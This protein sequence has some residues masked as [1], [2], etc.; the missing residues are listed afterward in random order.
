MMID[1]LFW[2][3]AVS[4]IG[5]LALPLG[6]FLLPTLKDHGYAFSRV[7]GLMM[8]GFLYWLLVSYKML[9]NDPGGILMALI[10]FAGVSIG[11]GKRNP[12]SILKDIFQKQKGYVIVVEALFILLFAAMALLRST[13]PDI[14][15]TEKPMEL[16]FINAILRSGSFPPNDPWLAGY[17][18]SY[19]Y[20]GYVI[21]AM[22]IKLTA[23]PSG[24]GF[25]LMISLVFSL[26]GIGMYGLV[27]NIIHSQRVQ[28]WIQKYSGHEQ[29]KKSSSA[30]I[31]LPLLGPIFTLVVSNFEG[32]FEFLHARGLFWA[33]GADGSQQSSFWKWLDIQE[34]VM[35]PAQPFSWWPNRPGGIIWWR[36]SRVLSDY[37][38]SGNWLEIIDEFPFFSFLL[39]DL[40]PHV[41]ALP[42][43]TLMLALVLNVLCTKKEYECNL[44]GMVI[45]I[46]PVN[47]V[48]YTILLG[49][50]AF[51]NTWD[52]PVYLALFLSAYFIY[53]VGADGFK[54]EAI[55]KTISLGILM[56]AGSVIA[57]IPFYIGF[58]SQAGGIIP[59]VIFST[60]GVH[61]WIMFGILLIPIFCFLIVLFNRHKQGNAWIKGLWVSVA[62]LAVIWGG[63]FLLG[64]L[65]ATA[66]RW[67][68]LIPGALGYSLSEAG[69]YFLSI[70]G[71]LDISTGELFSAALVRR[72]NAPGT[73]LTLLALGFLISSIVL[74]SRK[75]NLQENESP[76]S[77]FLLPEGILYILLVIAAAIFLTIIPEFVYLRDQFGWRMN[78]IFK[79]YYQAWILWS[80]AA[81]TGLSL[82]WMTTKHLSGVLFKTIPLIIVVIGFAYPVIGIAYTTNNFQPTNKL[83]LDGTSYMARYNPDEAQAIEWLSK[84]PYGYVLEAVGGSYSSYARV[85]TLSGLPGVLGWP[86]HES[87]W[88][89]GAKEMGNREFDIERFYTT[90]DWQEAR[91][92]LAAYNVKYIY[93]GGLER[94][95]YRLDEDKISQNLTSV[96]Q[97]D[98]VTIYSF[99]GSK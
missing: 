39:A 66:P 88:R 90:P 24:I 30:G 14:T 40:H 41:L 71:A 42:F 80:L 21:T 10:I 53:I 16:A 35:A 67:T 60:R 8:T 48:F 54:W 22:M 81:A 9:Q 47:L 1:L 89:G 4:I 79:F 45:H 93:I 17:S 44:L 52:F 85:A 62:V 63:G 5:F 56:V 20:F 6:T 64:W 96:Y 72:I 23:T 82:L 97:N 43:I 38:Y 65:A 46:P 19:Y 25:N 3:I 49:G 87:Q 61:F 78:T 76:G 70:Q 31:I 28:D 75:Q 2:Y 7:L 18:I 83:D 29:S 26:T 50:M 12:V 91:S 77:W 95:K 69:S 13:N 94:T 98:S 58:S 34:L 11:I 99:N 92:I 37:N 55:W 74:S 57:Y 36:A 15:G 51:L 68:G 32:L 33:S 86:P 73:W 84:A 59:S 27:Y